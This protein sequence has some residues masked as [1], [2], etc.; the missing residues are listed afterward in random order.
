M[1][2]DAQAASF[3]RTAPL[4]SLPVVFHRGGGG[5]LAIGAVFSG[6]TWIMQAPTV[7]GNFLSVCKPCKGEC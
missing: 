7:S 1:I 2:D 3:T 5:G 4:P 6:T